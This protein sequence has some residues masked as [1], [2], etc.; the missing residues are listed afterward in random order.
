MDVFTI[1]QLLGKDPTDRNARN[2]TINLLRRH[3]ITPIRRGWYDD[4]TIRAFAAEYL[5]YMQKHPKQK[6][7]P[8]PPD[9]PSNNP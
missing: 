2:N 9:N 6:H 8:T 5:A 7:I 3:A 4:E 1:T